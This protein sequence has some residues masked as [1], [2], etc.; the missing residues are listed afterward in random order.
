MVHTC[1]QLEENNSYPSSVSAKTVV[2]IHESE[3]K[4]LP[5]FADTKVNNCSVHTE[6]SQRQTTEHRRD[7]ATSGQF[8][9]A[10]KGTLHRLMN[11]IFLRIN[12]LL[13]ILSYCRRSGNEK[14]YNEKGKTNR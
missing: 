11:Q 8:R 13:F 2:I 14:N 5:L 4:Y 6:P 3:G 10:R 1:Y 9:G 7:L 12:I